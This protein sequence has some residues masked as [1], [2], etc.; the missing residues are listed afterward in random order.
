MCSNLCLTYAPLLCLSLP[1]PPPLSLSSSLYLVSLIGLP[2]GSSP[3][4]SPKPPPTVA[5][6]DID[7]QKNKD[8]NDDSSIDDKSTRL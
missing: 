1:P 7:L 2:V 6:T 4:V 8:N 5:L 3:R